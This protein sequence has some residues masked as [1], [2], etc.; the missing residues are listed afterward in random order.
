MW[1]LF[2]DFNE[3]SEEHCHPVANCIN[4]EGSFLCECGD[5]YIGDGIS[6]F[7]KS[8]PQLDLLSSKEVLKHLNVFWENWSLACRSVEIQSVAT[9]TWGKKGKSTI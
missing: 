8:A 1:W 3:C 7:G 9:L 5:G 2:P 4:T 6:C